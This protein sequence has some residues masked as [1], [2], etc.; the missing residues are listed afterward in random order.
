MGLQKEYYLKYINFCLYKYIRKRFM[1]HADVSGLAHL[2]TFDILI[3]VLLIR[4][5][6][7]SIGYLLKCLILYFFLNTRINNLVIA[8]LINLILLG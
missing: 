6:K 2:K 1:I 4:K 7:A 8:W 3:T 5:Y